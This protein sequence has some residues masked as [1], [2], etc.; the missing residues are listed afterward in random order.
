[1]RIS[2]SCLSANRLIACAAPSSALQLKCA[3]LTTWTWRSLWPA[4]RAAARIA[5]P[6]SCASSGSSPHSVY[7]DRRL[8]CRWPASW[9]R[10]S[11]IGSE[12]LERGQAAHHLRH[13]VALHRAKQ[14]RL[15]LLLG[16]RHRLA[17]AH[18]AAEQDLGGRNQFLAARRAHAKVQ[19]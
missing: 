13:D 1:M 12:R 7:S 5:S 11:C 2:I 9:S 10:R 15:F 17:V 19:P 4:A 16:Q 18:V 14:Q 6:A 3:P 8:F